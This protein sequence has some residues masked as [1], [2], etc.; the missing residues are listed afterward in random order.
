ML[1][2]GWWLY[3]QSTVSGILFDLWAQSLFVDLPGGGA[4]RWML[5]IISC[6]WFSSAV[7]SRYKQEPESTSKKQST[8]FLYVCCRRRAAEWVPIRRGLWTDYFYISVLWM[9]AACSSTFQ[10]K[11]R[12]LSL[13]WWNVDHGQ[14]A[15]CDSVTPQNWLTQLVLHSCLWPKPELRLAFVVCGTPDV[16]DVS[17]LAILMSACDTAAI[18]SSSSFGTTTLCRFSPSQPS[19]SQF[20]YP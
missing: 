6:W 15:R 4:S 14:Q 1:L 13:C 11:C 16:Q 5:G 7:W 8:K 10:S 3:M 18:S 17:V 20:F 2:C 12:H 9:A 19:L